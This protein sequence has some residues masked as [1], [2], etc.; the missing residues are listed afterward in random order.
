MVDWSVTN[1]IHVFDG[2]IWSLDLGGYKF[3]WEIIHL[4]E[5]GDIEISIG[6]FMSHIL[7]YI[8][9]PVGIFITWN[10]FPFAPMLVGIK[11]IKIWLWVLFLLREDGPQNGEWWPN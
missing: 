10:L 6:V 7:N 3:S 8:E 9:L 11:R 5:N 1:L 2:Y 4:I